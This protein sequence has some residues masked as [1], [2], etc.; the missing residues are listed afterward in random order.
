[1]PSFFKQILLSLCALA[2][3]ITCTGIVSSAKAE[4]W[5][6]IAQKEVETGFFQS[7][8]IQFSQ[9]EGR[10]SAVKLKAVGGT[11]LVDGMS[12]R[13]RNGQVESFPFQG[14][15]ASGE[16][17]DP[18]DLQ[19]DSRGIDRIA[20]NY[21]TL[22]RIGD[23][24]IEI[25]A[26]DTSTYSPESSSYSNNAQWERLGSQSANRSG[27]RDV[28][29]VDAGDAQFDRLVLSVTRNTVD[30]GRVIVHYAGG[31]RQVFAINQRVSPQTASKEI[32]LAQNA[33][34]A[35]QEVEVEYR[36]P[37][38]WGPLG[39]VELWG[40]HRPVVFQDP[41]NNWLKLAE[42][43]LPRDRRISIIR[44]DDTG[45]GYDGLLLRVKQ[46]AVQFRRLSVIYG[47]G[48]REDLDVRRLFRAGEDTGVLQLRG[49]QG[50]S[51]DRIEVETEP[52]NRSRGRTLLEVWARKYVDAFRDLGP[53]WQ[54]M[55]RGEID[56][57]RSNVALRIDSQTRFDA[58]LLRVRQNALR[59]RRMTVV[60]GNGDREDVIVTSRIDPGTDSEVINLKGRQGRDISRIE[61]QMQTVGQSGKKA[62]L[63][64]WGKIVR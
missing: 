50:R 14:F 43:Y 42:G 40:R 4:G 64:L 33:R 36:T 22:L 61:F 47:N 15:L 21:G 17:T 53:R 32:P 34:T 45:G 6:R 41:G 39:L 12:I 29:P 8:R 58:L 27:E 37:P 28:F 51:I 48:Y 20:L 25:W 49:Q 62:D 2:V 5:R 7:D 18:M 38:G 1:M 3:G 11:V 55:V 23:P 30:I 16:E 44:L 60:Y 52:A 13:Y 59:I 26:Y 54:R 56:H 63:E 24:R 57:D 9:I 35:I 19:G 10:F 31:Q 46:N